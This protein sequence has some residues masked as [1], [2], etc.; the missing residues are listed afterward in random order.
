MIQAI[1][2][3]LADGSITAEQAEKDLDQ[4]IDEALDPLREAMGRL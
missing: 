3:Q 4:L 1:R 2:I